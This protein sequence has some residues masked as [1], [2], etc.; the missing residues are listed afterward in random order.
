MTYRFIDVQELE[1]VFNGRVRAVRR[2]LE[3][4]SF[5]VNEIALPPNATSYPEHDE[6]E[7]QPR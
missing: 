7:V 4:E 6:L 2:A 5:G 3:I 1:P